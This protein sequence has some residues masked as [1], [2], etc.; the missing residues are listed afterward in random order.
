MQVMLGV[1]IGIIAIIAG[2]VIGYFISKV[3]TSK[4]RIEIEKDAER[5]I[6]KAEKEAESYRRLAELDVRAEWTQKR[7][8]FEQATSEKRKELERRERNLEE[9]EKNTERR[10]D[11][12][13]KKERELEN[14]ERIIKSKENQ[15]ENKEKQLDV[16]MAEVTSKLERISNMTKEDAKKVLMSN[17]EEEARLE[18]MHK[19]YEIKEKANRDSEKEAK[20]IITLAIQ[21]YAQTRT[22]ES[23]V[24]TVDLPS[25]EVKGRLIGREGRNIKAFEVATGVDLLIDDTPEVVTISSFD[26]IKREVAKISLEKLI[27]DG[28]IHPARIEEII[29]ESKKEIE[30]Y[31]KKVGEETIIE[32]EIKG[33]SPEL[34]KLL[35]KLK[36]RTSYGQNVLE[37]SKEVANLACLM[38]QELELDSE[39]A[40]R[41]G[42]LH[43]IGKSV[44]QD[45][46]GTHQEIG[47]E[48]AKRNGEKDEVV[49]A[50]AS[51]HDSVEYLTPIAVLISAADAISGARPGARRET[52]EAY[53]ERLEKL[54]E[55]ALRFTGVDKAYAIQAGREIRVIVQPQDIKDEEVQDIA[56]RIAKKIE[57]ELKYPG[58]IKVT[59]V[60]EKRAIQFAK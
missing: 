15:L 12:I 30:A 44:S 51:H 59:V 10:G 32:M 52:F 2:A 48:I 13:R 39:L 6:K 4:R 26:P 57:G 5:I 19:I 11:L 28:R 58:Q 3:V 53:V 29:E 55:V 33:L 36:F 9:K 17:L 40:K 7:T 56:D 16:S 45:T 38:A 31:L 35:G 25:D 54:E 8:D 49:K 60:R 47:A 14:R 24:T 21:R 1:I 41:A 22:I 37:H 43:D 46:V 18:A 27:T 50:I 34:V 20:K 23:T 42:L